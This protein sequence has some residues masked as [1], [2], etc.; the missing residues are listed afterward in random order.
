MS[1][2]KKKRNTFAL[3]A[4]AASVGTV[5]VLIIMKM[6]VYMQSGSVSVLASL[7]DSF[8]DAFVSLINFGAIRYAIRPADHEHRYGHGKAE[9]LAAIM[10]GL[11]IFLAGVYLLTESFHRF[12]GDVI[13]QDHFLSIGVMAFAMFA[14][15]GLVAFQKYS[16]KF[17]PSLAVEADQEHYKTDIALNAGVIIILLLLY[18]GGP[19]WLD[20]AFAICVAI[21]LGKTALGI[22]SKGLDML[23]DRELPD[24][25]RAQILE[26]ITA[27]KDIKGVHDLRTRKS[28]MD[29]HIFFDVEIDP[30]YSLRKASEIAHEVEDELLKVFP[31]AEIMIHKDPY[32]VP[33]KESRHQVEGVH[34]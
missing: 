10:Q 5:S 8:V 4:G 11:F 19:A 14:S 15:I 16:L 24:E 3:W 25:V 27:H 26:I 17:A 30:D 22:T 29:I 23:L 2:D 12:Q 20:P 1:T 13:V 33:H 34:K 31:N 6:F 9:G 32:G 18:Y 28:G 21:Y 7:T